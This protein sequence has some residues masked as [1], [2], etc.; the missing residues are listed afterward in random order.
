[1]DINLNTYNIDPDLLEQK[2]REAEMIG[3]LPKVLIVVHMCGFPC[4]MRLIYRLAKKYGIKIIE[5]ASHATGA[6]MT[7]NPLVAVCIAI[8]QSS[9][10]S[11]ENY[12]D[13]RR[14]HGY[15][16]FTRTV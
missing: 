5:D 11:C 2:L 14:W 9:F 1:M 13:R 4:E 6:F 15:N 8:L 10:S 16:E 3:R 12:Y 7:A